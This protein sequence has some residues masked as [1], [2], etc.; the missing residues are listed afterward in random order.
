MTGACSDFFDAGC[1]DCAR[2]KSSVAS[3]GGDGGVGGVVTVST[4]DSLP[5]MLLSA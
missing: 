5:S 1:Q 4:L 2:G 3:G